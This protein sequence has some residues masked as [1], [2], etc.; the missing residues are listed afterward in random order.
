MFP[1]KQIIQVLRDLGYNDALNE[2]LNSFLESLGYISAIN[3]GLDDFLTAS[4]YTGTLSEKMKQWEAD[5]YPVSTTG[6]NVINGLD[7]V[8]NGLDNVIV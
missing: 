2:A 7:N 6:D 3:E 4:G 8:V 5:N 1:T